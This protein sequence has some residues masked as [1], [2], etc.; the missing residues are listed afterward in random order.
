MPQIIPPP[1]TVN[2]QPLGLTLPF[3]GGLDPVFALNFT[4][5]KQLQANLA[6]F[7]N[8]QV[9]ELP[10]NP[11]FG[12]NIRTRVFDMVNESNYDAIESLI[13]SEI[14]ANFVGVNIEDITISGNEDLNQIEV[15]IT[16]SALGVL[17]NLNINL[18]NT[19]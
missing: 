12:S 18:N 7:F 13:K 14:N 16:Y 9:G 8:T 5:L 3:T 6:Y 10:L 11:Q 17:Q 2:G 4:T 1:S 15:A 19:Q